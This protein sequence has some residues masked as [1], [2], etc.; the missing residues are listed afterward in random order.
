MLKRT[1]F[2]GLIFIFTMT[3]FGCQNQTNDFEETPLTEIEEANILMEILSVQDNG[4]NT[5]ISVSIQDNNSF[6]SSPYRILMPWYITL[7]DGTIIK[8]NFSEFQAVLGDDQRPVLGKNMLTVLF[9][10]F[11]PDQPFT[12]TGRIQPELLIPSDDAYH[13]IETH[14]GKLFFDD[15]VPSKDEKLGLLFSASAE[16]TEDQNVEITVIIEGNPTVLETLTYPVKTTAV[17]EFDRQYT[18]YQSSRIPSESGKRKEVLYFED[19][20][21]NAESFTLF[22]LVQVKGQKPETVDFVFTGVPPTY[23]L[24]N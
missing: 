4:Q 24:E 12:F 22:Y 7:D 21:P 17:D 11:V 10:D 6:D 13:S 9:L 23:L 14:F 20:N 16:R 5:T 1:F 15:P 8:S 18:S 3:A 2:L 19:V